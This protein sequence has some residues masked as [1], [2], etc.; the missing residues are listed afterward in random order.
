MQVMKHFA[1]TVGLGIEGKL[2]EEDGLLTP[3][4]LRAAMR[5]FYNAWERYYNSEI[6]L[7][8]KRLI[9]LVSKA[10]LLLKDDL[11]C[12]CELRG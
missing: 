4:S 9:A 3:D 8:V 10:V 7:N 5:R 1:E 11:G 2:D 12:C 6:P